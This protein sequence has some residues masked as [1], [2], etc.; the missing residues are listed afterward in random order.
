MPRTDAASQEQIAHIQV[1][2][3]RAGIGNHS[4]HGIKAL[5][6]KHPANGLGKSIADE[7]IQGLNKRITRAAGVPLRR[8][9][10]EAG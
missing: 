3:R 8:T 7:V 4:S 10:S 9:G 6:G 5:L 2:T 1:L